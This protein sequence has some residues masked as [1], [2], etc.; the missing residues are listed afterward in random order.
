MNDSN[1]KHSLKLKKNLLE[2]HDFEALP[3]E[4][5]KYLKKIYK[6]DYDVIRFLKEDFSQENSLYLDLY[7]ENRILILKIPEKNNFFLIKKQKN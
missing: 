1:P 4:I 3:K 7:P 2:H 6:S 5:Y